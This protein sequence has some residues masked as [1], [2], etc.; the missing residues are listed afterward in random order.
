[1][2]EVFTILLFLHVAGAIIAFGPT[3]SFPL[4]QRI[5]AGQP[6]QRLFVGQLSL[7]ITD[8]ITI[9]VAIS[10]GIT[11]VLMVIT[12]SYPVRAWLM[13]A[14]VLY[15]ALLGYSIFVARPLVKRLLA[16]M[17]QAPPPGAAPAPAG[18]PPEVMEMARRARLNGML[19]GAG[20]LVIVALMVWKP[21]A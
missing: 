4:M 1:M 11:G 15:L 17:Q 6:G 2:S 10:M 3:F 13:V 12:T 21:F 9:P 5:A 8:R 14:V 20:V 18:P 19:M 16:A 7:A